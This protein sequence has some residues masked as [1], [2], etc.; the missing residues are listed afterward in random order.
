MTSKV[1]IDDQ[2]RDATPEEAAAIDAQRAAIQAEQ[3]AAAA[4]AA[5]VASAQA[6]LAKLGLTLDE[7]K[8]LLG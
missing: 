8:A 7:I 1:Q 2:V 5:A 6:K 4:K 3:D